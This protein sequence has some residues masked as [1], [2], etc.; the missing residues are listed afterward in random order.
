M[1][2]VSYAMAAVRMAGTGVLIQR[3]NAVESI[4]HVNVLC[5][6]K[7]GTLTTNRLTVE[8]V[9]GFDTGEAEMQILLGAFAASA[10]SETGRR[11]RSWTPSPGRRSRPRTR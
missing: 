7:T 6:D 1:V 5:L 10:C 9:R 11:M 2:T 3:M 4:S 8:T